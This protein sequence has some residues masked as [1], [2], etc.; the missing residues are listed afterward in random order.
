[1][2]LLN[3]VVLVSATFYIVHVREI[4]NAKVGVYEK[5]A[6]GPPKY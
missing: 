1:M 6:I 3:N 5:G 4:I 2:A